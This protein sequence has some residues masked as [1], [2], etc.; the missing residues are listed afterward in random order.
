MKRND[1][2]TN[3]VHGR[4]VREVVRVRA[5]VQNLPLR[6]RAQLREDRTAIAADANHGDGERED[7]ALD[8]ELQ[9]A[10]ANS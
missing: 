2:G 7:V 1:E 6:S 8:R 5:L 9:Q 3:L 10:A 4:F